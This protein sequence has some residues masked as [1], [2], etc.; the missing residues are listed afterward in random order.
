[1]RFACMPLFTSP[2]ASQGRG[3]G[4]ARLFLCPIHQSISFQRIASH[5]RR[6][7]SCRCRCCCRSTHAQALHSAV[8]VV[9]L[10]LAPQSQPPFLTCASGPGLPSRRDY[11]QTEQHTLSHIRPIYPLSLFPLPSVPC[12]APAPWPFFPLLHRASS[13]SAVQPQIQHEGR[14]AAALLHIHAPSLPDGDPNSLPRWHARPPRSARATLKSKIR[15]RRR[16]H[17]PPTPPPPSAP[18]A[19]CQ[20]L[21]IRPFHL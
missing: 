12:P 7:C 21:D 16:H 1:M 17:S 2:Y 6:S 18:P 15:Q 3:R 5:L 10:S 11:A 20:R 4:E 13:I 14:P 8:S 19:D 9:V